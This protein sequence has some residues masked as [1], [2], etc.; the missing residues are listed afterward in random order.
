[1]H[2]RTDWTAN[3]VHSRKAG[4]TGRHAQKQSAVSQHF[5]AFSHASILVWKAQESSF[6][7]DEILTVLAVSS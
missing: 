1:M 7:A 5:I 4:N 3:C 2:E 6:S